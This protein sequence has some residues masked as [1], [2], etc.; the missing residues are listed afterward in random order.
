MHYIS[1]VSVP[2]NSSDSLSCKKVFHAHMSSYWILYVDVIYRRR[3]TT[4]EKTKVVAFVG[5]QNWLM[6]FL[7][8]LAILP[9]TIL[10]NRMNSSFL[11]NHP[12]ANHPIIQI[13]QCKTANVARNSVL[14]TAAMTFA[15]SSV[16]IPLLLCNP[17]SQK[18]HTSGEHCFIEIKRTA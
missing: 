18:I 1:H 13:V 15:L 3:I 5:G 16:F 4:E 2:L 14:Q 11:S 10:K 8:A 12:V 7:A 6:K 17:F 9:R